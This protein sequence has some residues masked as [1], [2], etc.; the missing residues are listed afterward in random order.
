MAQ[1]EGWCPSPEEIRRACEEIQE[2][3]E[4]RGVDQTCR[5]PIPATAPVGE[6]ANCHNF[7]FPWGL[8]YATK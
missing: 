3:T 4:G 1:S 7:E 5:L 2:Q 6:R 8:N